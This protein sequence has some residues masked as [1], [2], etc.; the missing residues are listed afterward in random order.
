MALV[1]PTGVPLR[2]PQTIYDVL[3][4]EEINLLNALC[5]DWATLPIQVAPLMCVLELAKAV[6]TM[7]DRI[8]ALEN[9][10]DQGAEGSDSDL[11]GE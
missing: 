9:P 4:Q 7:R 3:S 6:L 8:I 11:Q 5:P 10:S 2:K 1:G